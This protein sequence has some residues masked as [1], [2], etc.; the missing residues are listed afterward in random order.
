MLNI[1]MTTEEERK[2][3]RNE[4]Q[5]HDFLKSDLLVFQIKRAKMERVGSIS[6]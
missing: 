5:C 6:I 2:I 4:Q 3:N 1:E